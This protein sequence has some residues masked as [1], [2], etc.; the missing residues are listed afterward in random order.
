MQSRAV[1]I[2]LIKQNDFALL[3]HTKPMAVACLS[4]SL[5]YKRALIPLP[6][7]AAG[8][9]LHAQA[10]RQQSDATEAPV[11]KPLS[12]E[13]FQPAK[14]CSQYVL[15]DCVQALPSTRRRA[16]RC[17]V[18]ESRCD[19]A[20]LHKDPQASSSLP[21]TLSPWRYVVGRCEAIWSVVSLSLSLSLTHSLS[22]ISL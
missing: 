20:T 9:S 15:E 16:C 21:K 12:L 11:Y 13:G 3:T 2:Y 1:V 10:A 18:R 5:P 8:G 19:T 7:Q 4:P 22:L 6:W 14:A 17:L